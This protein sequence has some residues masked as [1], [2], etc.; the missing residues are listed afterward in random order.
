MT[1]QRYAQ[2]TTLS[3]MDDAVVKQSQSTRRKLI[4]FAVV[5]GI[6]AVLAGIFAFAIHSTDQSVRDHNEATIELCISEEQAKDDLAASV[7][8]GHSGPP[9]WSRSRATIE[10]DCRKR[11]R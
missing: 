4:P 3:A 6:V 8:R 5:A 9:L 10:S 7:A 2:R 11:A 1:S